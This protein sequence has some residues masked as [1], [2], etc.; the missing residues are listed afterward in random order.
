MK[1]M[2]IF[3]VFC[4]M[5]MLTSCSSGSSDTLKM[6]NEIYENIEKKAKIYDDADY[7]NGDVPQNDYVKLSG[8]IIKSDGEEGIVEKG[9]RFILET[10]GGRYQIVNGVETELKTGDSVDVFGEYYGIIKALRI[11]EKG[12]NG[13]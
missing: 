8:K 2:K 5:V 1:P 11:D 9:N 13:K 10:E 7:K 3:F 6:D 4:S 12:G